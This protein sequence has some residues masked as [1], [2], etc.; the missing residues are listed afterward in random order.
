MVSASARGGGSDTKPWLIHSS[1]L[2]GGVLRLHLIVFIV[3]LH[4][5]D[6]WSVSW[7][8]LMYPVEVPARAIACD[9]AIHVTGS[10]PRYG[11]QTGQASF[12]PEDPQRKPDY[13]VKGK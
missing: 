11:R 2:T 1:F 3:I 9:W 5:V 13:P 10:K 12:F 6:H 8:L 7:F 4:R